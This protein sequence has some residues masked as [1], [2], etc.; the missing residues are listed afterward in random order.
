MNVKQIIKKIV[1]KK[2]LNARHFFFAY[3]GA[4]KYGFPSEELIVIGITGTSGKSSI[5]DY[6][7]QSLEA[8]GLRVG[9]LSTVDFYV[10][11]EQKMNDQKMTMLGLA[12]IQQYLRKM[13]E[14]KC[15]I[16]IV[17][18]TSEGFL[19]YRHAF[20]N[21]DIMMLT[22]LYPEHIES[23]GSFEN[24][25]AAKLGIFEYVS[26]CKKKKAFDKKVA[27]VNGNNEYANE[28]LD[29]DFD[30]KYVF[31]RGDRD[32]HVKK[33]DN[34]EL[35]IADK[36][37]VAKKGLNFSVDEDI[38]EAPLY[39]EFTVM[40][41]MAVYA[42]LQALDIPKE[43]IKKAFKSL[44]SV[45]GRLEFIPEAK[46][47]GFEVIVDYAFEPIA[48]KALYDVVELLEPKRVIHV[49]GGTGGGRD[50]SRRFSVGE[51]VGKHADIAIVTDEDPYDDDPMKIIEDVS[52]A[53]I[54]VGKKEG[55]DLWKILDRGEAIAQ[56][57]SLAKKGDIILITGKGSEQGMVVKGK[58]IP[59]DDRKKV[60]DVLFLK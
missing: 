18:T 21:Y 59:H 41:L 33:T 25:K 26:T 23:H 46:E 15:E 35:L 43:K 4:K 1:P 7:R 24:Y 22:N 10:A 36:V 2:I 44:H 47:K 31:F 34:L 42:V 5:T 58:I 38:F 52:S 39:G 57:V 14:A 55:Q 53:A 16:A 60:R 40:N 11:G 9:S 48:I 30:E 12:Q 6:L 19:Q 37:Q 17:E 32:G 50:I 56:A 28:F 20:I 54:K 27:I 8:C 29:K 45:P 51:F 13:V 49:F 3:L